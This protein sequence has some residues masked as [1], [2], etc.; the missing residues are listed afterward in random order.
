MSGTCVKN[1]ISFVYYSSPQIKMYVII[2]LYGRDG[3][4]IRTRPAR[5]F[6][7]TNVP[8][9]SHLLDSNSDNMLLRIKV[10]LGRD[11]C[12]WRIGSM[13]EEIMEN[14]FSEGCF[15]N[16]KAPIGQS[17]ILFFVE[18]LNNLIARFNEHIANSVIS[19]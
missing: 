17:M 14:F 9:Y 3:E 16:I 11:K 1:Y 6:R 5:V 18:E 8:Y 15:P 13:N 12:T 4:Y 10:Q 19:S 2:A 7:S